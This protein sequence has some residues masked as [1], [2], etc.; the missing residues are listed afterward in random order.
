MFGDFM[1]KY[2]KPDVTVVSGKGQVVIPKAIREKLGI[3]PKTKLIVY[4]YQDAVV[5]KKIEIP[6]VAKELEEIYRRVD[7]RIAKQGELTDEEINEIIR[8]YRRKKRASV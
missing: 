6:D 8:D 5:M 7:A 3:G 4:G 2:E 1:A